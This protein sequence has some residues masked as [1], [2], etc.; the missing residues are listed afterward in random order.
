MKDIP[1]QSLICP[2]CSSANFTHDPASMTCTTCHTKYPVVHGKVLFKTLST[3]DISD[4]LD[5]LKHFFKKYS[6][7]YNLMIQLLSPIYLDF[8]T[9][10][11][12]NKYVQ[13]NNAIALNLGSGNSNLSEKVLNIDIFAYDHVNIVCDI[14]NIPF[15]DNSVDFIINIA[16]LEHVPNPE[17]VISETLRILKPGGV[18]CCYFPFIVPFHASPYDFSRRTKEG[19]KVLFK[20]F[21]TLSLHP[22]C[23]PTSGLLWVLQEWLAMV[24]SFGIKKLYL[25]LSLFFM[26]LTFPL[27]FI[28][29]LLI[30]HPLS[31][32]ISSGFL[33]IGRKS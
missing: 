14:G 12:I 6:K 29:L 13:D 2:G 22:G 33:Y 20:D 3:S 28:D 1:Y 17:K 25:Y 27:K 26:I 9:K 23:G 10:K 15:A 21:E 31:S 16:A 32:N 11:I 7:L 24:F 8:S 30:K 4:D 19:M 18:V 5:K